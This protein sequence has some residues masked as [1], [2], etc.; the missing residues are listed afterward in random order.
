[1]QPAGPTFL[2]RQPQSSPPGSE[3]NAAAIPK[4]K[5]AVHNPA[6]LHRAQ[7]LASRPGAAEHPRHNAQADLAADQSRARGLLVRD[8]V[9]EQCCLAGVQSVDRG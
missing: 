9:G 8:I 6:A 7:W 3:A 2:P 5:L 1:M 4:Q